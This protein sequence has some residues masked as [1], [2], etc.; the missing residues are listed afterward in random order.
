MAFAVFCRSGVVFSNE[1]IQLYLGDQYSSAAL[2]MSI[3]LLSVSMNGL[4][5]IGGAIAAA[6]GQVKGFALRSLL[7][8]LVNL[9]FTVVFVALLHGGAVGSAGASL[10]ASLLVNVILVW[11]YCRRLAGVSTHAWL[12]EVVVPCLVPAMVSAAYCIAVS[13]L[14]VIDSWFQLIAHSAVS[15]FVYGIVVLRF[16]LRPQD[17]RDIERLMERSPAC[18]RTLLRAA[19]KNRR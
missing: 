7:L 9:G 2:V 3:L 1:L 13:F 11:P 15:G 19:L 10:A 12:Q 17:I 5:A 14:L 4:N 16:G 8:Q 6:D 18:F